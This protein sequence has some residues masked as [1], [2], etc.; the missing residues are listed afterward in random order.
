MGLTIFEL[1]KVV[2]QFHMLLLETSVLREECVCAV[3]YFY[4][5]GERVY[6]FLWVA[7]HNGNKFHDI[8]GCYLNGSGCF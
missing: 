2:K 3:T 1:D 5:W 4:E 8:F 7:V 6:C